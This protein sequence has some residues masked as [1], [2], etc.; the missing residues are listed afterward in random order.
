MGV[1]MADESYG[2]YGERLFFERV[3]LR[4][5]RLAAAHN[6]KLDK[7]IKESPLWALEFRH[8]RGGAAQVVVGPGGDFPEDGAHLW[9]SWHLDD[10]E[11]ETR[12]IASGDKRTVREEE[13][14][15]EDAVLEEVRR[16]LGWTESNLKP[17]QLPK[18]IWH[19]WFSREAFEKLDE[20]LPNPD[21]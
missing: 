19:Q 7:W 2:S 6:L 1:H 17:H 8:P 10:Y 9:S 13:P 11:S 15:L 16:A 20:S 12:R 3:G 14:L 4:L 18:G 5:E 21:L